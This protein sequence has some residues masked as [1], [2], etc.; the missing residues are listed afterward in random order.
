MSDE[1]DAEMRWANPDLA[2]PAPPD[3]PL[4]A[5]SGFTCP[6]CHGG[7]WE[8]DDQGFPRYRCRV[9]HGFSAESLLLSNRADVE[10]ALWTA[11]RALEE[12]AALLYRL[13]DRAEER[14]AGFTSRH[15][16]TEA[17]DTRRQ[18]EVLRD[19][20]MSATGHAREEESRPGE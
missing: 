10:M 17:V 2:H 20:L 4:G 15:F 18:A 3:P 7:L 14:K 9:G 5:P 8:I 19:L 12:R 13:A 1:L 6:E 16:R 11:Y